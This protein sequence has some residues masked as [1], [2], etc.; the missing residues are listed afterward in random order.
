MPDVVYYP[1][2]DIECPDCRWTF[3]Y[4]LPPTAHRLRCKSCRRWHVLADLRTGHTVYRATGQ[5]SLKPE[6][7][8]WWRPAPRRKLPPPP[9]LAEQAAAA[10]RLIAWLDRP[11]A[12]A[13]EHG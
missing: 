8:Q 12:D 5:A 6:S 1:V 9:T 11:G 13:G 2:Y 4:A 10:R 7:R 3:D